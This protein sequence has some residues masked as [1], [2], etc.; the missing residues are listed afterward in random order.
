MLIDARPDAET[1]YSHNFGVIR[2]FTEIKEQIRR[3]TGSS[4]N[5]VQIEHFL[6][7]KATKLKPEIKEIIQQ[8]SD[9]FAA[10]ILSTLNES[11]IDTSNTP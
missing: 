8:S 11:M 2:L 10:R 3:E 6:L 1:C 5:E 4:I 9:L 7:G